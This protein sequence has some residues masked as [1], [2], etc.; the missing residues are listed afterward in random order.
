MNETSQVSERLDN[1][2]LDDF[3]DRPAE[4]LSLVALSDR[5]NMI[6][7]ALSPDTVLY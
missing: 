3:L 6:T 1:H 2:D 4:A 5:S 7:S